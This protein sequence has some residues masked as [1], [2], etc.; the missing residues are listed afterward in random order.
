LVG[1]LP[2]DVTCWRLPGVT[3]RFPSVDAADATDRKLVIRLRRRMMFA[4]LCCN[5]VSKSAADGTI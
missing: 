3:A 1:A 4:E 2:N 5:R